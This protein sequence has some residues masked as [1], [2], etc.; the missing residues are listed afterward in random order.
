MIAS[1]KIFRAIERISGKTI[2]CFHDEANRYAFK[3]WSTG[4]WMT[5]DRD[6]V[7]DFAGI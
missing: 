2:V 1:Y 6:F 3:V 7:H 5:I 4:E